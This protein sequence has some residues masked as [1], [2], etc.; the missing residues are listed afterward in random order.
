MQMTI[1]SFFKDRA[2][3]PEDTRLMGAAFEHVCRVLRLP[4]QNGDARSTAAVLI[5]ELMAR[6]ERNPSKL[7]YAAI[8]E[9]DKSPTGKH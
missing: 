5:I 3:D 8:R 6:G 2:F 1:G 7:A 4:Q 9:L